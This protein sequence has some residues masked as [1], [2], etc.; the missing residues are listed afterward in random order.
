M[1]F[2]G[3][4]LKESDPRLAPTLQVDMAATELASMAID[5]AWSSSLASAH[6][7][8]I[9]SQNQKVSRADI[10]EYSLRY[11]TNEMR[12]ILRHL[13]FWAGD[14]SNFLARVFFVALEPAKSSKPS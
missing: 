13:T 2:V 8:T 5:L 11:Y 1:G 10:M 12:L 14:L 7:R 3:P 9:T 4:S 6:P